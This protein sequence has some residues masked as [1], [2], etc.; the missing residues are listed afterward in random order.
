MHVSNKSIIIIVVS[1]A[2]F[3]DAIDA[4][5]INT[6]IPVMAQTL[7]V[8]A[9]DLKIALIS[10]LLSLAILIPI[11]GWIADK[12][13]TKQVFITALCVF[14]LSSA[15]CGLAHNLPELVVARCMQGLGGSLT[16][17]VGRL[18][19]LRTFERHQLINVM[20]K[21]IMVVSLGLMLGP[22]LGGFITH[23]LSWRWIFLLNI[24]VG[25][26]T[27]IASW[28]WLENM[29]KKN[30]PPLDLLGFILFG[31]AL[32]IFTFGL[33][34]L[35]E[36]AFSDRVTAII[37]AISFCCFAAY[38]IHSR[39]VT[40]PVINA[41]MFQHRTFLISVL[42][43]L[44]SRFSFGGVPFLLPLLLQIGLG[45]TPQISGLL[46]APMAIG[47][48][49]VKMFTLRLLRALGFRR[50]LMLNTIFVAACMWGFTTINLGISVYLISLQTFLFGLIIAV[51][52]SAM[53]SLA[54]AE[55]SPDHLSSAASIMGTLQQIAQS[56][57]V[58]LGAFLLR[59]YSI[60]SSTMFNLTIPVF[61]HAF[62]AMGVI[63]LFST[64]IFFQL[65]PGDGHEMIE[66]P[67]T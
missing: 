37:I 51:Q 11:S 45:Y 50:L 27:I 43:N 32:S 6:A 46:I 57:G 40:N 22:V 9:V 15:W 19:L 25:L 29:P 58:A 5:V 2:L 56:F 42:G 24:P 52:Y 63:T 31:A 35:S 64:I 62:F 14:T 16:L 60:G 39:K 33:S 1:F 34:A 38:I 59:Y 13:G 61:H 49:L 66:T 23:Y 7:H 55:L 67:R 18:I 41:S 3:M 44:F 53:N 4:T 65:K 20:S 48:L 26:I 30:V 10:Y 28:Y 17:P 21:V 12:F 54:Y 47:V 36:T 8:N